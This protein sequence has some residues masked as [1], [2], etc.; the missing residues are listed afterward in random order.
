VDGKIVPADAD[1][2][3]QLVEGAKLARQRAESPLAIPLIQLGQQLA[4]VGS[5]TGKFVEKT[6]DVARLT[7]EL[8]FYKTR[9]PLIQ[10]PQ[11]KMDTDIALLQDRKRN[12]PK[13]LAAIT[14]EAD[15]VLTP[16]SKSSADARGKARYVQGLALRNLEK[17]DE[18]RAAFADALKAAPAGA[19]TESVKKSKQELTDPNAYYIPRIGAFADAGKFK[20]ALTE[21]STALKVMPAEARLF[22]IRGLIRVV[23]IRG[24]GA[25]I[26]A[27]DQKAIR[28]DAEVAG[29]DA[30]LAAESAYIVGMLEE[31]LGNWSE[32]EK[33]FRQALKAH[34]GGDDEAGKYRVA[35]ARLLLR[36][37]TEGAAPVP[38]P[39]EEKKDAAL[40]RPVEQT[41]VM[42]PWSLLAL[43]AVIAQAG[44]DEEDPATVARLKE[45][46]ELANELLASKNDKIKGQ[47]HLILGSALSRQGKRTEGIKEY[48]K[49]L[50]LV[51]PGIES[52]EL[53]KL[54]AEHPAFQQPDSTGNDP[55][56]AERH[57]GEGYHLYWS[58]KYADAEAQFK[59]S[60]QYFDKDAR[61]QYF[62]GLAQYHQKTK[63]K[64]DAAYFAWEQGARLEA[65]A[66]TNPFAVREINASLERVQGNERQLLNSYRYKAAEEVEAK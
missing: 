61:F 3:K 49:G 36:D 34:Q 15:W 47:G 10:S 31:E 37:R 52:D 5:G 44:D 13:E 6:F 53:A 54:I 30:K 12:N 45:T 20:A 48:S 9:E 32:A 38:A 55:I 21:T 56:L 51:Y 66:A 8:G 39:A 25:K 28:A 63:S 16:E 57:F 58:G 14:R 60:V 27:D 64:R 42:H 29:K 19:W 65:K 62:L 33:L 7:A 35:L 11:Q 43:S 4:S 59:K 40:P 18:A 2:S 41:I 50:K 46:V 1:P 23:L 17:F 26:T 22:A 24:Q